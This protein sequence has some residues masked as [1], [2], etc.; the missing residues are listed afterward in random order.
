MKVEDVLLDIASRH[1][2]LFGVPIRKGQFGRYLNLSGEILENSLQSLENDGYI[3]FV[4]DYVILRKKALIGK[5][6]QENL[7]EYDLVVN[8]FESC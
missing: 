2:I 1:W 7:K 5:I 6:H 3:D 4:S 8:C